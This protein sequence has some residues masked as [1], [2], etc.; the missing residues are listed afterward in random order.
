MNDSKMVIVADVHIDDYSYYN[1]S[2]SE[3]ESMR[4]EGNPYKYRLNQCLTL[5]E[6]IVKC[7]KLSGINKVALL[8][9]TLNKPRSSPRIVNT[10]KKFIKTLTAELDVYYILGQHDMD[11]KT[12]EVDPM[13]T[14]MSI[15]DDPKLHYMHNKDLNLGNCI[16]RFRNWQPVE[17]YDFGECDVALGHVSLGFGQTPV[18]NYKVGLFG[19]IHEPQDV[20][21]KYEGSEVGIDYSIGTPYQHFP[22]QPEEGLIGLLDCSSGKPEYKRVK[23][24]SLLN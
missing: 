14:F 23:S 6:A 2:G 16:C 17:E 9:D 20:V 15:I 4:L 5:A 13:D 11:T 1:P 21:H 10:L 8:G 12:L 19:D 24:D 7:C 18:G 3:Y 22:S